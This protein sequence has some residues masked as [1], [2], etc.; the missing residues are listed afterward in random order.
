MASFLYSLFH[1]NK[2]ILDSIAVSLSTNS[3]R[4]QDP[5]IYSDT[6]TR[7]LSRPY[8][9]HK[10]LLFVKVLIRKEKNYMAC[11]TWNTPKQWFCLSSL[12]FLIFK[13]LNISDGLSDLIFVLST[14]NNNNTNNKVLY[15]DVCLVG[16]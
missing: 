14:D 7:A 2:A 15:G 4:R 12:F 10:A 11:H 3:I 1:R 16:R 5:N 9:H 8:S 6:E 13:G